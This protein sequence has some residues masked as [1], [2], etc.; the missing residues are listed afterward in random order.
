MYVSGNVCFGMQ[1]F[2]LCLCVCV[3]V[4]MCSKTKNIVA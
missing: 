2:T 4:A 3:C 1:S